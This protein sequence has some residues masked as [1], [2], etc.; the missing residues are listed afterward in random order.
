MISGRSSCP[1][2]IVRESL[3][4]KR[5]IKSAHLVRFV[6][7][8][9]LQDIGHGG[10]EYVRRAA[11]APG[12]RGEDASRC[13]ARAGA[14]RGAWRLRGERR[15]AGGSGPFL[16]SNGCSLRR[17]TQAQGFLRRHSPD[18]I[19]ARG[20]TNIFASWRSHAAHRGTEPCFAWTAALTRGELAAPFLL[21]RPA[22]HS[23]PAHV[24]TPERREWAARV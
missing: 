9:L 16:W 19:P 2:H 23:P 1:H 18:C 11:L 21:R 13:L 15:G 7:R 14:P 5:V 4:C 24:C 6:A 10:G 12:G 20:V 8:D 22:P 17:P 3:G